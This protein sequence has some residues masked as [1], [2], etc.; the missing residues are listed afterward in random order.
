MSAGLLK[1]AIYG[2]R[3]DNGFDFRVLEAYL[4][5]FFDSRVVTGG[6][7]RSQLAQNVYALASTN[8]ADYLE[9][10]KGIS[11]TVARPHGTRPY[12]AAGRTG[13]VRPAGQH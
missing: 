4:R 5:K 7:T 12:I 9:A 10:I 1:Y 8:Y 3:I 2:G 11:E 13:A 6:K